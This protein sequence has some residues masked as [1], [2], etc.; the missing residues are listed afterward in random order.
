MSESNAALRMEAHVSGEP[1][2]DLAMPAPAAARPG[3]PARG[4]MAA[5]GEHAKPSVAEIPACT[6]QYSL[7]G[8]PASL[9]EVRLA[10]DTAASP[11]TLTTRTEPPLYASSGNAALRVDA[12]AAPASSCGRSGAVGTNLNS[13]G[14]QLALSRSTV[15]GIAEAHNNLCDMAYKTSAELHGLSDA[16]QRMRD[17]VVELQKQVQAV[18]VEVAAESDRLQRFLCVQYTTQLES[19]LECLKTQNAEALRTLEKQVETA[20]TGVNI[21]TSQLKEYL[22][23]SVESL[24]AEVDDLVT[25]MQA[26]WTCVTTSQVESA[27]RLDTEMKLQNQRFEDK[28]ESSA[29]KLGQTMKTL[30]ESFDRQLASVSKSL[31]LRLGEFDLNLACTMKDTEARGEARLADLRTTSES[32]FNA[33][34]SQLE[35]TTAQSIVDLRAGV[36][37]RM[38]NAEAMLSH[39][40]ETVEALT[41][42]RFDELTGSLNENV[43]AMRSSVHLDCARLK[44][45]ERQTAEQ[46]VRAAEEVRSDV[47][48]RLEPIIEALQCLN[49]SF[50][51]F[52]RI[53][54]VRGKKVGELDQLVR[55][56]EHRMWP[57]RPRTRS[58]SGERSSSSKGR[59]ADGGDSLMR[60]SEIWSSSLRQPARAT[61][62]LGGCGLTPMQR[63]P[64]FGGEASNYELPADSLGK[65]AARDSGAWRNGPIGGVGLQSF[66][67]A[68]FGRCMREGLLDSATQST[69]PTSS[70][71]QGGLQHSAS[72]G[73]LTSSAAATP[74]GSALRAARYGGW[75]SQD[76]LASGA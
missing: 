16:Q 39:R 25:Q 48:V 31:D 56:V 15:G 61:A 21:N 37:M 14:D 23:G 24:S 75:H 49:D 74:A 54:D 57:W 36:D 8:D 38:T 46:L 71:L 5:T 63:A 12:C 50:Q 53:Q 68:P 51:E 58:R 70:S 3:S 69:M 34:F 33:M 28:L 67:C 62:P 52:A 6:Q 55:A 19:R 44:D 29:C 30:E 26:R 2:A 27:S 32:R 60:S 66:D 18:G 7:S 76:N 65:L 64:V 35:T 59:H 45:L 4:A 43:A 72:G 41:Q 17:T 13:L 40:F 9:R 47:D 10:L 1:R 22:T 73:T 11:T 42:K 20:V